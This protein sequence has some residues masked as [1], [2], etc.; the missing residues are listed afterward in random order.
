MKPVPLTAGL[1]LFVLWSCGGPSSE[2]YVPLGGEFQTGPHADGGAGGAGAMA[3]GGSAAGGS[4]MGSGGI[5][6]TGGQPAPGTGG[7][8]PATGGAGGT[9]N[10][11]GKP[12]TGGSM[13][14]GGSMGTG[15]AVA[16]GGAAGSA[17]SN[18][19]DAAVW[20]F[21]QGVQAWKALRGNDTT[22]VATSTVFKGKQALEF[23]VVIT[24]AD[25]TA[26]GSDGVERAVGIANPDFAVTAGM[27]FW[28]G[29]TITFHVWVPASLPNGYFTTYVLGANNPWKD[30]GNANLSRGAWTTINLVAPTV[31]DP[32]AYLELGIYFKGVKSAWS[33]S[34]FVDSVEVK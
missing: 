21:E 18:N 9:A 7:V 2:T 22:K 29:K 24:A 4:A 13:S 15:G 16:T 10:T 28:S 11:G 26:A 30:S 31:T 19:G 32:G 25:V 33:G 6:G 20:N 1:A 14:T 5:T 12:G 27:P 34:L 23:P 8:A 3:P 17:P